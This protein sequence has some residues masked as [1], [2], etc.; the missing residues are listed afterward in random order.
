MNKKQCPSIAY[1][2][3]SSPIFGAY[4]VPLFDE[5]YRQLG[6]DFI[7]IAEKQ[8]RDP[9]SKIAVHAGSFPRLL[10]NSH[11]YDISRK[12]DEGLETPFGVTLTP[13]LVTALLRLRPKA[14]ISNNFSTWTLTSLM[15]GFP[16]VVFWE[17]TPHTERTVKPWRTRLR[18]WIVRHS[19]AFVANGKLSKR[20]LVEGLGANPDLV[21]EGGMGPEL[22]PPDLARSAPRDRSAGSPLRFLFVGR[23]VKLKGADTLLRAAAA[24]NDR[25][26]AHLPFEVWFQGDGPERAALEDLARSLGLGTRVRFLGSVLAHEVWRSYAQ[27]DIFVLPTYQDNWPLV[28]P[29]A[30]FMAMPILLS[31]HA[32]STL[33]L[34]VEGENGYIFDPADPIQ[35]ADQMETY[36]RDHGSVQRHGLKSREIANRYTPERVVDS[37]IAALESVSDLTFRQL[38]PKHSPSK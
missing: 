5:L 3:P 20:Y 12:H 11:R 31:H 24:L 17:G 10:L 28:V 19:R 13:G 8:Q 32:G 35:L 34:V 16:T 27:T 36:L 1:L 15:L 30:M 23:L 7:L 9:N 22:P 33:D 4:R 21:F 25:M 38:S 2:F 37:Y 26:R 14:V 6:D 29:E 18:R